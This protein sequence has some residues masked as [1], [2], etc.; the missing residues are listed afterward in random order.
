MVTLMLNS[1]LPCFRGNTID[2]LRWGIESLDHFCMKIQN[3]F[4]HTHLVA[5]F[6]RARFR[7]LSSEKEAAKLIIEVVES[8]CLNFHTKSY[9]LI[10]DVQ[11]NIYYYKKALGK[12]PLFPLLCSHHAL[13]PPRSLIYDTWFLLPWQHSGFTFLAAMVI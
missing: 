6:S 10:Q 2:E 7:S 13:G 4:K 11:Q 9:D 5:T 12:L 1:G 8:S 3:H